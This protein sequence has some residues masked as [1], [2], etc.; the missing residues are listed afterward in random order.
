MGRPDDYAETRE[1]IKTVDVHADEMWRAQFK[2]ALREVCKHREF[3]TSR[4]V[5]EKMDVLFREKRAHTHDPRAIGPL[6]LHGQRQR[7]MQKTKD[8]EDTGSHGHPQRIWHSLIH[9]NAV[10]G[11]R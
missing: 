3:F 8:Y 1:A 6:M 5:R 7:W 11:P 10:G 9:K 2:V 4:H